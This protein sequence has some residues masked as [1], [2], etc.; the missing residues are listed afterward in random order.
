VGSR[1]CTILF[2]DIVGSTALRTALGDVAF[3]ERRRVHD[4]LLAEAIAQNGGELVKHE[5]DG[6]MAVFA[7][8]ADSIACAAAMQRAID[9][10]LGSGDARFSMR[11]GA[12][13]G[14]VAEEGGDFHGIPVVEAARL[15]AAASGGQVLVADVV[16]ALAGSRSPH[17][18]TPAGTL[19][20]KGLD[21]PMVAWEV[22]WTP[23]QRAKPVPARLAEVATR[24]PCVGR[25]RQLDQLVTA[26][27]QA[28]TGER[29]LALVAGEPGIGKTRLAAAL[30]SVAIEKGPV[31]HGWCDEETGAAYEA[32]VHALGGFVRAADNEELTPLAA[33]A[34]DLARLLPDLAIRLGDIA[35]SPTTDP[36]SE[37][38][39]LFDAVDTLLELIATSG[40]VLLVLDDLHWADQ[41]TLALLR[42]VLRS[43][44]AGGLLV[45]ATY[46]DTDIDRRHPLGAL[47][48]DLRREP[49]IDR[50]ALNG[51]D[52]A[53]V[54]ALIAGRAGHAPASDFVHAVW[55]QTEGN[56]FFAEE[57]IA[58]LAETGAIFERD[59]VWTSDVDVDDLGLPEGVRDVVGRRLSRLSEVANDMLRVAA[60]IGRDFDAATVVAAGALSRDDVLSALDE[61]L[62]PG[63]VREI[64]S[65]PGRYAFA[66]A[67]VRQ[68]LVE[69]I[70]GPL[71]ARLHWR[72]GE[73]LAASGTATSLT[74]AHH[75][76]EGVLAGDAAR[77]ALATVL[78]AEETLY[79]AAADDGRDLARRA[80]TLLDDAAL[81]E[82]ELRCRALLIIGEAAAWELHDVET[83]RPLL[84]EASRLATEHGWA[85]YATRAAVA[86][87]D[88]ATPGVFDP[89]YREL[90]DAGLAQADAAWRPA[91]LALAGSE[92]L[93]LGDY[94]QGM[95]RITEALENVD[96]CEPLSRHLVLATYRGATFGLP[97]SERVPMADAIASA[98]VLRSTSETVRVHL[99]AAA[100]RL[101]MGDRDGFEH[102]VQT[103]RPMI[104]R[105][106]EVQ[107]D[108]RMMETAEAML[109]GR[110]A[111]AE[112][113]ALDVLP[114]L[115]PD[116]SD[117]AST[118]AQIAGIWY[119]TGRDDELLEALDAF[120]TD[121]APQRVLVE[122]VRAS[123]RARS[124]ERDAVFDAYRADHFESLPWSQLR[125]GAL[126]Q[127]ATVAALL[128]DSDAARDLEPLLAP[129]AGQ[130]FL[131]PL[132][133]VIFDAADTSRGKLLLL[134]GRVDEAVASLE[135][136]AALCERARS[137]MLSVRTGPALAAALLARD[138]AGDRDRSRAIAE[139]A[140]DSAARIGMPY[141]MREAQAVLG[142]LG[143]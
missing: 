124:G 18:L 14:D 60:V 79:V 77:A 47:L 30:A 62:A 63:L 20:L 109:D 93:A 57:V 107:L 137:V 15:C 34:P 41:Q 32:W 123:A 82:P 26:W 53:G 76:C 5:G 4:Q 132:A 19:E 96:A 65:A 130:L 70:S 99:S 74:V 45:L 7:S 108:L 142:E 138:D 68:T 46:R 44:R 117:A 129:Y 10:K 1:T 28:S 115:D 121:A 35:P 102:E 136:A 22:T 52:Q 27:T 75:L 73:V 42:W 17:V 3:D 86:Y 95:A 16:R 118:L 103:V 116:S 13:A 111:D 112:Q 40:P 84:V 97:E 59:G 36:A 83:L 120:A 48:G 143:A 141:E 131:L 113:L 23:E 55:D 61:A 58:H 80:I 6:V 21:A 85:N 89:Q 71:R 25:D 8:A 100:A 91:L 105:R 33:L 51:L 98:E 134:L 78:A 72:I 2:T 54:A 81:A 125:L 94:E 38:A 24:G 39:R 106:G 92:D 87:T 101:R 139:A 29:R 135:A 11:A 69:E 66:H 37:R 114:L 128:G 104:R 31:L 110:F 56:P 127:S 90:L 133:A 126:A 43:D 49:R 67:L 64:S 9:R 122:L 140:R 12:S 119:L 88:I 50:V